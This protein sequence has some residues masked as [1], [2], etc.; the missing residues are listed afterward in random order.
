MPVLDP[1]NLLLSFFTVAAAILYCYPLQKREPFRLRLPIAALVL[2]LI[3]A[4]IG[5]VLSNEPLPGY[6][7][8]VLYL[9]ALTAFVYSIAKTS[10]S[11]ALY[12]AIW[13]LSSAQFIHSL[14]YV[15]TNLS[16]L[17]RIPLA[18]DLFAVPLYR[19]IS[20]A[21]LY[22][23]FYTIGA[24]TWV[25]FMPEEGVYHIGP[26]QL[27]SAL[28]LI[29]VFEFLYLSSITVEQQQNINF[30][31]LAVLLAEFYCLSILYVQTAFFKKSA[32]E[33]E[34]F[35]MNML[36]Q[37]HKSQYYLTKENVELIN[38]RSHDL[39]H[40]VGLLRNSSDNQAKE[41]Y[42]DKIEQSVQL[43]D[44]I[45]HTGNEVLDTILS[46]KSLYC[47]TN[48]I[49]IN[50]VVD[51]SPMT[52]IDPIDLYAILGNAIDNA[53]EGVKRFDEDEREKR[54]I[55][56]NIFQKKDFL[57]INISN[58]VKD[59]PRFVNGLPLTIKQ[60]KDYHGFGLKSI[61]YNV[62]KYDGHFQVSVENHCFVM[63]ILFPIKPRA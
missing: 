17:N 60:N 33:K 26:R 57:V 12:V 53:I 13:S 58:P 8:L 19:T 49:K 6:T 28:A 39:K 18:K 43:Y 25:R 16:V 61:R 4:T 24:F 15:L 50:C 38:R 44:S 14:F 30:L 40:Q 56:I 1:T 5:Q 11:A 32:I 54:L 42:L 63:K 27:T 10:K 48:G 41:R 51:S 3:M 22:L 45:V 20:L 31:W 52:F 35:T 7:K 9:I 62:N 34:Y 37:K 21:V 36:W 47:E 23:L 55:D 2:F 46:D 59:V 29:L